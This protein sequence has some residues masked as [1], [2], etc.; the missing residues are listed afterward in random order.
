MSLAEDLPR[1]YLGSLSRPTS[2]KLTRVSLA[3][4]VTRPVATE[5][6]AT[7]QRAPLPEAELPA[8]PSVVAMPRRAERAAPGD[9]SLEILDRASKGMSLILSR[10]K[11][12]EDHVKQVD[13]WSNAQI[14]AAEAEAARWQDA[15]STAEKRLED[16]QRSLEIMVRRAEAAEQAM[17]RDKEALT[18]LQERIIESFGF[19]SDAHDAIAAGL[20]LD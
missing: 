15:A 14:Q 5:A 20:Q 18:V 1:S 7:V 8:E 9:A 10:Y 2:P 19:G 12:L 17:Y 3:D 13:S 11:Q 16:C 6:R 4:L